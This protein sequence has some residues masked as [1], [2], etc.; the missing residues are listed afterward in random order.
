MGRCRP[1]EH[2]GLGMVTH[3][4]FWEGLQQHNIFKA[5]VKN[6]IRAKLRHAG[7]QGHASHS[8]AFTHLIEIQGI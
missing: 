4:R 3:Y 1:T 5:L 6:S 2:V 8:P 7:M